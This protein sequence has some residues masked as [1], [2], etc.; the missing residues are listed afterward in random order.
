MAPW[1]QPYFKNESQNFLGEWLYFMQVG[2][3]SPHSPNP[4][5][6]CIVWT[7]FHPQA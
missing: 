4:S 3:H 7:H 1:T 2:N 6:V 5:F